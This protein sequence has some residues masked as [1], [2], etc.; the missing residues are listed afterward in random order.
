MANSSPAVVI[1]FFLLP[2]PTTS[3]SPRLKSSKFMHT[4]CKGISSFLQQW[5]EGVTS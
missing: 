1:Q 5:A 2:S 3:I 4:T